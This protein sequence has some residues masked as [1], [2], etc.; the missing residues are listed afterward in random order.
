MEPGKVSEILAH[1]HANVLAGDS[2][3]IVQ[4]VHYISTIPSK[5]RE[6]IR[7]DKVI[8]I[9]D[10]LTEAQEAHIVSVLDPVKI[11]SILGSAEAGPFAIS[12]PELTGEQP[13]KG[14]RDFVSDTRA[15]VIEIHDRSGNSV[16]T[17]LQ[18][19]HNPLVRYITGDIGSLHPIIP[20]AGNSV[21]ASIPGTELH[22]FRI[23]RLAGR[24]R[25]FSFKWFG[26][27][28]E[29]QHISA[30]MHRAGSGVLQWQI[31]LD[32][33][34]SSPQGTLEVRV[35]RATAA[36]GGGDSSSRGD[37]MAREEFVQAVQTFFWVFPENRHLFR[38]VFVDGL[39]GFERS[40]TGDR[41]IKFVDRFNR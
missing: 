26:E 6:E 14:S 11:L 15:M 22:H 19:L 2:S 7:L 36:D 39:V 34:A 5:Q 12:N 33:L 30:P 20:P 41:V 25:R 37:I 24:D 1:Y 38:I 3:Q 21:C 9:S 16:Q 31:I 23:L 35:L 32:R 28:F 17:S 4:V 40:S 13:P 8:Y 27:Y 29:F 18:R 10:A